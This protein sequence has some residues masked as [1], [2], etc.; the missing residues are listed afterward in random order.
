MTHIRGVGV[1]IS[2]ALRC[3]FNMV[4]WWMFSGQLMDVISSVAAGLKFIGRTENLWFSQSHIIKI[5]CKCLS[6]L[7][8]WLVKSQPQVTHTWKK[9]KLSSHLFVLTLGK[10]VGVAGP[11]AEESV[12]F[13]CS[14]Q[15]LDHRSR[16]TAFIK[17]TNEL[18]DSDSEL[19][20]SLVQPDLGA[21]FD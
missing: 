6:A 14:C 9:K 17:V 21:A 7:N 2:F 19:V 13:R 10:G 4:R 11:P 16:E 3:F 18:R 8:M 15:A 12:C 5:S 1:F 20:S